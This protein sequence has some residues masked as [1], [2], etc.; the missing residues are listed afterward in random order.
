MKEMRQNNIVIRQ[1][2]QCYLHALRYWVVQQERLQHNYLPEE[3]TD[4]IVRIL[5]Q[6]Y[7]SSKEA[8]PQDLVKPPEK[9]KEKSKW[10]DFSEAFITFMQRIR[11]QCGL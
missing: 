10:Q 11:Q 4:D 6:R 2:S 8:T 1:T 5:L 3:F 9:F 7:Q